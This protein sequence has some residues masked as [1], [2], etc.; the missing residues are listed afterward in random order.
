MEAY[1]PTQH[2]FEESTGTLT[3]VVEGQN[4]LVDSTVKAFGQSRNAEA[5][6]TQ[7]GLSIIQLT[8]SSA[9]NLVPVAASSVSPQE[10]KTVHYT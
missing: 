2:G 3:S 7:N 9:E 1:A 6:T 4:L 10:L 5:G 8:A